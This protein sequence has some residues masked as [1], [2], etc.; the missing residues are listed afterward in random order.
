MRANMAFRRNTSPRF[1]RRS[2]AGFTLIEI[3]VTLLVVS[4][5]LLGVAGLHSLSLRNNYDALM[6]SHASALASDIAD[7]MRSNRDAVYL[8][9]SDYEVALGPPPAV[10]DDSPRAIVDVAEWKETLAAQLPRGDGTIAIDPAT[11]IVTITIQWGERGED[12]AMTFIT[13]TGV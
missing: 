11:R 9:D 1:R 12:D 3:L 10:D 13:D 8:N 7:R 5:G 4:V 6:R 2:T